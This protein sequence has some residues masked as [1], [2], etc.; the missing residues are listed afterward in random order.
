MYRLGLIKWEDIDNIYEDTDKRS[1]S[2]VIVPDDDYVSA[3]LMEQTALKRYLLR[4]EQ[5]MGGFQIKIPQFILSIP[6]AELMVTI[7]QY[8]PYAE[9]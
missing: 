4:K 8:D 5:E 9:N 6:I 2:L 1:K 7:N 3:R